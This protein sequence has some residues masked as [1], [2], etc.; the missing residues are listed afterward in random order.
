VH[1]D[2]CAIRVAGPNETAILDA[3]GSTRPT[4]CK[5]TLA[6]Q[7]E[8]SLSCLDS[9]WPLI[10]STSGRLSGVQSTRPSNQGFAFLANLSLM[11]LYQLDKPPLDQE[12]DTY[13]GALREASKAKNFR[14]I[15]VT[16]GGYPTHA[17]RTRMM[18]LMKG[19]QARAAVISSAATVRFVVSAMA[20]LNANI[21][22]YS[23]REYDG[24]FAHVGLTAAEG[25]TVRRAIE[26]LARSL[27][28]QRVAA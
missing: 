12:W 14:T 26:Q 13:L 6:A 10:F 18:A 3:R 24:A 22:A 8:S 16:E 1:G 4:P 25:V 2:L 20:L 23:V 11:I 28:A 17:Q 5:H 27:G 9:R 19:S 21:N 15:V 7:I